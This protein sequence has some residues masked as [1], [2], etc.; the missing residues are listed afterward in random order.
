MRP[1]VRAALE[2]SMTL[3]CECV[4]MRFVSPACVFLQSVAVLVLSARIVCVMP[5]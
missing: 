5:V 3:L 1:T 2:A 4:P